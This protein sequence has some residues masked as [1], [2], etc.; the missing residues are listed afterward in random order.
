MAN[1]SIFLFLF[2]TILLSAQQC[3]PPLVKTFTSS[4]KNLARNIHAI[5]DE[6][7]FVPSGAKIEIST[8]FGGK[9]VTID[10]TNITTKCK[11]ASSMI[12]VEN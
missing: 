2:A 3:K 10:V 8:M 11:V 6:L 5:I 4:K 1:K 9:V 12:S 7:L